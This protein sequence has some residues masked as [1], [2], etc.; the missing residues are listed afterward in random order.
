MELSFWRVVAGCLWV[1]LSSLR[2]HGEGRRPSS[3][4]GGLCI[5][6]PGLGAGG[7]G[8]PQRGLTPVTSLLVLLVNR[9]DQVGG[10]RPLTT[11]VLLEWPE[12]VWAACV[13]SQQGTCPSGPQTRRV[14]KTPPRC[15][16][17][18]RLLSR[19]HWSEV[20]RDEGLLG[21][22]PTGHVVTL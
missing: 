7:E 20:C 1:G 16:L 12:T 10:A 6:V 9:L 2:D 8:S 5:T 18:S 17:V 14:C 19:V 4:H 21:P 13:L 15:G 11:T 22:Q 3:S